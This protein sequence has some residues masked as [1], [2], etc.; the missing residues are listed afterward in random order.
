MSTF[1]LLVLKVTKL[2]TVPFATQ[3][4]LPHD[5]HAPRVWTRA[6]R[7]PGAAAIVFWFVGRWLIGRLIHM[8]QATMH[9]NQIDPTLT[10]LI[11]VQA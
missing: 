3:I 4:K 5:I 1:S 9:R 7:A 8:V 6:R 11:Q 2:A 10:R